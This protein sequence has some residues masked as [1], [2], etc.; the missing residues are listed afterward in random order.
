MVRHLL[1]SAMV[2]A[3]PRLQFVTGPALRAYAA[4]HGTTNRVLDVVYNLTGAGSS[5]DRAQSYRKGM[6][7]WSIMLILAGFAQ[8][9]NVILGADNF[10][11]TVVVRTGVGT[12][13]S[14][15]LGD[16]TSL[17]FTVMLAT[18]FGNVLKKL[19]ASLNRAERGCAR[20]Q[21]GAN[22]AGQAECCL[23]CGSVGT[24]IDYLDGAK[25]AKGQLTRRVHQSAP[26]LKTRAFDVASAT[27]PEASVI[28]RRL[29]T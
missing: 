12:H 9:S 22:S 23:M 11:R 14:Y 19:A 4:V 28:S 29:L 16:Y 25:W 27:L 20:C 10:V 17:I 15:M 13:G 8:D 6:I 2:V 26:P 1:E 5:Y 24:G 3:R 18:S 21:S 7:H